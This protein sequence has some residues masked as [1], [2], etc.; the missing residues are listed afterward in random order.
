MTPIECTFQITIKRARSWRLRKIPYKIKSFNRTEYELLPG[1]IYKQR[2]HSNYTGNPFKVVASTTYGDLESNEICV[3]YRSGDVSFEILTEYSKQSG[4]TLKLVQILS[5][6]DFQ[7]PYRVQEVRCGEWNKIEWQGQQVALRET[8]KWNG[9]NL[10][11]FEEINDEKYGQVLWCYLDGAKAYVI[12][13]SVVTD[14]KIIDY[15]DDHYG[16]PVKWRNIVF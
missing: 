10:S 2:Y 1:K 15:L 4:Y 11:I 3:P 7:E 5:N 8:L 16:C 13:D 14:Q 12:G 9:H 6:R